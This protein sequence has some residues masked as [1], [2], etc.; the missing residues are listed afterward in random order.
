MIWQKLM[1]A[2]GGG[3]QMPNSTILRSFSSPSTLPSGLAFDGTNLISCD[4]I[5]DTIYVH[6]G[7]SST[8]LSSFLS[9][10]TSP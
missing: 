5:T 8:I 4:I 1:M 3:Y 10:S 7:V 9:P 2:A 6:D